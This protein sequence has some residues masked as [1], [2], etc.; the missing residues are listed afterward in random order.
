MVFCLFFPPAVN[1]GDFHLD[2][3]ALGQVRDN[4]D[5]AR[6]VPTNGYLGLSVN[7][8]DVHLS[9][10]SNMRF[11]RDFAE[12]VNDYDLYQ[13]VLH[14]RPL[15]DFQLDFGRQFIDQGFTASVIDGLMFQIMRSRHVDVTVYS[16]IPRNVEIGDFNKNDGLL[17]GMT[18]GVKNFHN[19]AGHFHFAWRK[20]SITE[21]DLK[22]NDE[23]YVG[24]DL[25]HQFMVKSTP[26]I[27]GLI[28]YD[29]AAKVMNTGTAGLDIYPASWLALNAEFNYYN[30]N[31]DTNRQ[32]VEGVFL[33]GRTMQG[34]LATTW[35]IV[36]EYLDFVQSYSYQ[37]AKNAGETTGSHLID[38]AF[39]VSFDQIGLRF[40]PG[41]YYSKSFGGHLHGGRLLVHEQFTDEFYADL[42]F[43]FTKY[44]K[45]TNNNDSAL[46][47]VLWSGYEVVKGLIISGGFEYNRNTFFDTDIR[48]S[49]KVSYVFDHAI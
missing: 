30:V 26:M 13:T 32:T 41:Y 33:P 42:I 25:S 46:S 34:R 49:F 20:N 22:R 14:Y 3:T 23:L 9:A 21:N 16:G 4:E 38:A 24:A 31:R 10:E 35:T 18:V 1:A 48:G 15:E 47:T 27:Y 19:T 7:E 17:S 11:F 29:V 12:K 43:D 36:P 2:A 40:E 28:E 45:I 5:M 6:E 39:E 37:Y 44:V 8:P